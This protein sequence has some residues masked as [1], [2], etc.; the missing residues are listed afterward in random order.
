[1]LTE[2]WPGSATAEHWDC[3][4]PLTEQSCRRPGPTV[5]QVWVLSRFRSPNMLH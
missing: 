5:E 4:L 3:P 2:H 1:M